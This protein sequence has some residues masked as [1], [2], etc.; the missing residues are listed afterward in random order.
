MSIKK[1]TLFFEGHQCGW[2]ESY[3]TDTGDA[4]ELVMVRANR[5][6]SER[7]ALLGAECSVKAIRVSTEG[8]LNDATL[9]YVRYKGNAQ[10]KSAQR[11]VALM[12][13]C[14]NALHTKW[15]NSYLRGIWD[16]VEKEHGIY[17]GRLNAEWRDAFDSFAL[18]VTRDQWGWVTSN[19]TN[20]VKV[21]SIARG[22]SED[23]L[24]YTLAADVF[25]PD[26]VQAATKM[27]VRFSGINGVSAANGLKV[28][29]PTAVNKVETVH[30]LAAGKY[31][32][33]G[34]MKVY[35]TVFTD[36]ST[37]HDTKIVSRE[38]GAPLLESVGRRRAIPRA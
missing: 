25:I 16:D 2:T 17:V 35:E 32:F 15:R 38:T 18:L 5:L 11:D 31:R 36:I 22:T 21:S 3:Y 14:E 26:Q 12:V 1:V 9:R 29:V 37:C 7:A 13:R 27:R 10:Y 6:A 19:I 24:I 23:T 33:G 8:V 34:E 20:R 28:V 30:A 4:H